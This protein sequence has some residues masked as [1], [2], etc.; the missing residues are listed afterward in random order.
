[1]RGTKTRASR[2][3][4]VETSSSSNEDDVSLGASQE[5]APTLLRCRGRTN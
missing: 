3:R 5:E 4:M 2:S 1:M